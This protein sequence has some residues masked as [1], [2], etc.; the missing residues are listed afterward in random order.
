MAEE[1]TNLVG[2]VPERFDPVQMGGDL[3]EAEHRARYAWAAPAAA[4]KR[5]LDAGC[6]LGYG[7]AVLSDA[8]A[9]SVVGVDVAEG[10]VEVARERVPDGVELHVGD[11]AALD[12]ADGEFDVVVCFEVIEHVEAP[13]AVLAELHRVLAPGG[14]L[15]V[16]SPNRDVYVPGNPHHIHEYLPEELRD[17]LARL[18]SS[19]HLWRQHDWIASA[20][21][22]DE[23]LAAEDLSELRGLRVGK[24]VGVAPGRE[25][26]T[27]AIAGDGPLPSLD[28]AAML[29]GTVELR[30]WLELYHEQHEVLRRQHAHFEAL[31]DQA[32]ERAELRRQLE[33]AEKATARLVELEQQRDEAV[34]VAR[35]RSLEVDGL[36]ATIEE[37]NRYAAQKDEIVRAV[38]TSPSWRI[39]A[40]LRALKRVV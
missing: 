13:D 16:S 20:V 8:G 1:V 30:K 35:Q 3:V 18:F 2:G 5:V 19:V 7:S 6:G 28:P 37:L 27:L 12:F 9:A 21:L 34:G 25:T 38:T 11:V 17:A 36:L 10:V 22:S 39:T 24:N 14:V 40:P 4:G 32:D 23:D 33:A 26:Y 29:T 15:L 31:S